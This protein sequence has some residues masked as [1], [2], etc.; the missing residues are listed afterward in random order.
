MNQSVCLSY[1]LRL[2]QMSLAALLL[3]GCAGIYESEDFDRHRMSRL[4]VP[5]DASDSFYFDVML[6]PEMPDDDSAAEA[7]RLEWLQTWV[8]SRQLCP[9]GY[10]VAERRPFRY[11]ELNAARHDLRYVV[12]C[13]SQPAPVDDA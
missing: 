13:R 12:K 7:R 9:S 11:D 8:E 3:T 6:S 10:A 1:F 2:C 4:T 5:F